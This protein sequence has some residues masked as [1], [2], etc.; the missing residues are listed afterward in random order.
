MVAAQSEVKAKGAGLGSAGCDED[1]S[2]ARHGPAR[3]VDLEQGAS[4]SAAR[5]DGKDGLTAIHDETND[6]GSS[7]TNNICFETI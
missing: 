4:G 3:R 5:G 1:G 7:I 2:V 6:I